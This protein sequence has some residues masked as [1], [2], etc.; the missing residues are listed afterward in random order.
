MANDNAKRD[1][2]Y[3]PALMGIDENTGELRAIKCNGDGEIKV[4]GSATVSNNSSTQ[5]IKVSKNGALVGTRQEINLIEGNNITLTVSDDGVDDEVDI[6]IEAASTAAPGGADTQVQ[7]NDGGVL[8]AEAGF[9]YNKT[10]DTATLA[11]DLKADR[12][13]MED[14]DSSHYLYLAPG[15]DLTGDHVLTVTTGDADRT[16]TIGADSS[17]SGTAYVAGGTDVPVADGGTGASTAADARTNLSA[18]ASGAN[19]DI[20]SIY[21]NNTGLKIKD[22]NASHG[23]II[24]PGSDLTADKTLTV[25]TGDADRTVTLSGNLTVGG[26]SSING[27]AYVSGGTDVSL[28]DGGTGASL[29]DPNADRILFWD[30]SAGASTW[31]APGNSVAITD[32][33]IDTIQD[34]R[35]TAN[36]TFNDLTVDKITANETIS[37]D[38]E[39]DNGNSGAADTVD[40]RLGNKQ[41]S[42]LT[43]N[44][45]FTFTAPAGP[46]NLILK[47]IQDGTGSRT[48]TW[49]ATVKWS[50]GTAPTLTTTASRVDIISLYYDGTNYFG[51]SVLNFSV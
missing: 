51:S 45:T 39:T 46:C 14:T 26:A 37:F 8:S 44:C 34:I 24:A 38:A 9:T 25:T 43:D 29:V 13:G 41:K 10:T 7:F 20:T 35:T 36:P 23:L 18:A 11:G 28:A 21:L 31:L 40:W 1:S 30:D 47:L 15:S 27:T 22:T 12:I 16:L 42:T 49:P 19:T 48:V 2:N 17:I 5:K 33:T 50:G 32:T 3:R 4:T 6:T